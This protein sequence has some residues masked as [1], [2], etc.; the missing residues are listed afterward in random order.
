MQKELGEISF[1]Y[2]FHLALYIEM[3]FSQVIN[4][5]IITESV[6][7]SFVHTKPLESGAYCTL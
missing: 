1:S 3:S 2:M 7:H 5:K 6:L 4:I